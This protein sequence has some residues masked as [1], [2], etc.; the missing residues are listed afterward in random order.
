ISV[1]E[2]TV[3]AVAALVPKVTALAPVNLL[4][5][6]YTTVPPAV[7]PEVGLIAVTEGAVAAEYVYWSAAPVADVPLGV[8]TVISTTPAARGGAV[9][10]MVVAETTVKLVAAVVPKDTPL[11]PLKFVPVIV[12]TVPPPVVPEV[13]VIAVTVGA[14]AAVY[15]N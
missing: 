13:G 10:R 7:L 2:I 5:V 12:T 4:P 6:M 14:A 11:A 15:V 3:K 8:V 1:S 9:A